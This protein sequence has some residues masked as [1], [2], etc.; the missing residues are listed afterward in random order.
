ML[1]IQL[2]LLLVIRAVL[3]RICSKHIKKY[4]PKKIVIYSRDEMKQWNMAQKYTYEPRVNFKV[5]LHYL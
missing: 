3:V 4:I 1:K 5:N 2:F